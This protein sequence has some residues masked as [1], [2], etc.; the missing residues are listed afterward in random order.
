MDD[1]GSMRRHKRRS[2]LRRDFDCDLRRYQIAVQRGA[3]RDAFHILGGNEVL[4][5]RFTNV[6]NG[7]DVGVIQARSGA[8]LLV[9]AQQHSRIG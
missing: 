4:A 3:E 5:F 1:L 2:D 7:E 9:Q 8:R 6:V